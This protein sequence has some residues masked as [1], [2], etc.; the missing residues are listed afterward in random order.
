MR[1]KLICWKQ[2]PTDFFVKIVLIKNGH[3]KTHD[4]NRVFNVG[5]GNPVPDKYAQRII[6]LEVA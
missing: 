6:V 4:I 5:A 1:N 3:K 2:K